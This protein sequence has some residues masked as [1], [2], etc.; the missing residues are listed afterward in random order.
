MFRKFSNKVYIDAK[1]LSKFS[2]F[3]NFI[4][5]LLNRDYSRPEFDQW[6]NN[7]KDF[8]GRW[9]SEIIMLGCYSIL[10]Q[11]DHKKD[12]K[13]WVDERDFHNKDA[14]FAANWIIRAHRNG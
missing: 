4:K 6:L 1:G 14:I 11:E 13:I 2:D 5:T 3:K 8:V 9:L 10:S 12:F 7:L